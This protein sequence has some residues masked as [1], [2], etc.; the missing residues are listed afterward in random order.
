MIWLESSFDNILLVLVVDCF[1]VWNALHVL[2]I[3]GLMLQLRLAAENSLQLFCLGWHYNAKDNENQCKDAGYFET[4]S[5]HPCVF[6]PGS[7]LTLATQN[8]NHQAH[9]ECDQVDVLQGVEK[10]ELISQHELIIAT[11]LATFHLIFGDPFVSSR[12]SSE[13]FVERNADTNNT[14]K[15]KKYWCA[16]KSFRCN[17]HS[18]FSLLQFGNLL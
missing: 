17:I 2:S 5:W 9:D 14:E 1:W 6:H 12:F 3:D 7:P 16:L 13:V 10:D 18:C 8:E 11:I 4:L 15:A